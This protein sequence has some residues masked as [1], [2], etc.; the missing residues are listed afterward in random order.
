MHHNTIDINKK[1][2]G[3]GHAPY[4]IAEAGVNH[5]GKLHIAKRMIIAAKKAG[6]DAVKFQTFKA[7][8]VTIAHNQMAKYQQINTRAQYNQLTLL[9]KLELK[10][11]FYPSLLKLSHRIGITFLS[12]PHGGF[13]SIDLLKQY[14]IPAFKFGS[15]DLTNLPVL[16]YAA[17]FGKPMIISTGMA[18]LNEVK[19]AIRVISKTGNKSIIVLHATTNYPCPSSEVNL[20]AMVTMIKKLFV[21]IGYSD[22]TLG[23]HTPLMAATLGA[24]MIEKHVTLDRNMSGPDHKASATFSELKQLCYQLSLVPVILGK[25]EKSPNESELKMLSKVRKSIVSLR[26]IQKGERFTLNNITIKRPATG[27]APKHFEKLLSK[28]AKKKISAD[29]PLTANDY[30]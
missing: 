30:E 29:R 28:T 22:H 8:E 7:N 4:V 6:A 24:C 11:D 13:N 18:T 26:E 15:G 2:I 17:K 10:N 23:I 14:N 20:N 19:S 1:R 25:S 12:T 9:K 5:N 27:I 21:P 16:T 3:Y